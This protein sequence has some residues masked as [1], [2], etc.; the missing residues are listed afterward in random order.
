[1]CLNCCHSVV[2]ASAL[3]RFLLRRLCSSLK[4]EIYRAMCAVCCKLFS[5]LYICFFFCSYVDM[6][7]ICVCGFYCYHSM[8]CHFS[9]LFFF[10]HFNCFHFSSSLILNVLLML[11]IFQFEWKN[12]SISQF[13]LFYAFSVQCLIFRSIPKTANIEF[14]CHCWHH[15]VHSYVNHTFN[16]FSI[17]TV[18]LL[19][20]C[21]CFFF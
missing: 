18:L 17:R 5:F 9:S 13:K 20:M 15:R 2:Y 7:I 11:E 14:Q 1:M 4:L 6:G 3:C 8:F 21:C 12:I 10:I 19:M 16:D